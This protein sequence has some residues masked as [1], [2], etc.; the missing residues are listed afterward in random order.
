MKVLVVGSGG[1]EHA[2]ADTL[3]RSKGLTKLFAAPGNG[4]I[5][6]VATLVPIAA[7]DVQALSN[8]AR[9]EKIDLTFVGPEVP[10]S[11]GI[12][13]LFRQNGLKIVGPSAGD[14]RL[15]SSKSFAKNLFRANSIPTADFCECSDPSQALAVLENAQYPIVIKADGLA[16][17]KGVTIVENH[18]EA[19]KTVRSLME[20]KTLGDAGTKVVIEQFLEGEEASFHIFADG[21]VFQP[22]VVAQ[23]HKRRFDL[24]AGPNTGGMGAYSVDSILSGELRQSVLDSIVRPTLNAVKS[25]SGILYA[26]LMLTSSGPKI[27]EYNVRFGDPETQVI[28]PRLKTDFLDAILAIVE[29]RLDKVSLEWRP[30]VTASVTLVA[31]TY[32]GKVQLGKRISGL[33]RAN[34]VDNVK[35]YHAGTRYEDGHYYTAGG[36]VLNVTGRG[37]TLAE[38]LDRAYSV[39]EMITFEGKDYRKDIGKRGLAKQR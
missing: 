2:I 9:S 6:E 13:D 33:E 26:G 38:A 7:D 34:R 11:K 37:T 3:A 19:R 31:N 24:D 29:H 21:P 8:F 4:G 28:L 36:R 15:E 39:A 32:P 30:D 16:A 10:L 5:R 35:V 22:M 25:Y 27:I 23:D 1:R 17:G 20:T 18:D 14:A 12:A